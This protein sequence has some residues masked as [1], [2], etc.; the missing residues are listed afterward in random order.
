[1]ADPVQATGQPRVIWSPES[2]IDVEEMIKQAE[3]EIK[4]ALEKIKN[5]TVNAYQSQASG[6]L[7]A[8]TAPKYTSGV[9]VV[10]TE[11]GV[12]EA[13]IGGWLPTVLEEGCEAFDMK[14]GLLAGRPSRVIRLR[15]GNFR[16][17]SVRSKPDSWIHPGLKSLKLG[18]KVKAM[19]EKL[20]DDLFSQ[21]R[22]R[23]KV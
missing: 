21:I 11:E 3:K 8:E 17:V 13:T 20:G 7:S 18:D 4:E 19:I 2:N 23:I 22:G 6:A 14:P 15:N 9:T 10:S 12:I 5:E 16:T 1:M